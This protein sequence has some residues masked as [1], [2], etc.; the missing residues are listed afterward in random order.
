MKF[1]ILDC[2]FRDGGYYNNWRFPL[3]VVRRQIL[4]NSKLGVE[5]TEIGFRFLKKSN[6]FGE[7]AFSTVDYIDI[8]PKP[9]N[10]KFS[11]MSNASDLINLWEKEKN[12]TYLYPGVHLD[13]KVDLV[14]IALHYNEMS[15][16]APIITY[17]HQGG[18][19][20]ALNLMQ[21]TN[22]NE[23]E[24]KNFIKICNKM[25]VSIVY[26]ADSLG[27]LTPSKSKEISAIFS[28]ISDA[29]FGIHAHD[30]LGLALINSLEAVE[31]G[32]SYIDA[33]ITGMGRGPGNAILEELVVEKSNL[34]D[35]IVGMGD[36][37]ELI[38]DYYGPEQIKSG[39]GKSLLY[40]VAAIKHIH[41]TY[42]QEI[43]SF[44]D[45]STNDK[46]EM[47]NKIGLVA[48]PN[49]FSRVGLWN[50]LLETEPYD[51]A[52]LK[53]KVQEYSKI[54]YNRNILIIGPS[55]FVTTNL[56]EIKFFSE[57]NNC[58]VIGVND[59]KTGF[60]ELVSYRA[61]CHPMRNSKLSKIT[62]KIISP[63][64]RLLTGDICF[65][66]T[67][68]DQNNA[69]DDSIILKNPY[70]LP[71][72]FGFLLSTKVKSVTLAG[73]DGQQTDESTDIESACK[74]ILIGSKL[75]I[76]SITP[77]TLSYTKLFKYY[78]RLT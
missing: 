21:I 24:I 16:L 46:L 43:D 6:S 14:R 53:P 67:F 58:L 30:N 31:N 77:T 75:E 22:F 78:H 74:D 33:S 35:K 72:L 76:L 19:K 37:L 20:V 68:G 15:K 60:D 66:L 11:V 71:Y 25:E 38:D 12:L 1:S 3:D 34:D 36:L 52:L 50:N 27:S 40:Y 17:L 59:H 45:F 28:N 4:V 54:F 70:V 10:S 48:K 44:K 63:F 56:D 62:G 57:K 26:F 61:I 9:E 42:V 69:L 7:A 73:F 29:P 13:T 5:I 47:I 32:A 51:N 23:I 8:L 18:Y 39:W 41:P 65:P 2:T 64:N 49:K 55:S